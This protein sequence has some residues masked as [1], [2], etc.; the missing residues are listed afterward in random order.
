MKPYLERPEHDQPL[1]AL[2]PLI[3]TP[4][5]FRGTHTWGRPAEFRSAPNRLWLPWHSIHRQDHGNRKLPHA[6]PDQAPQDQ[7]LPIPPPKPLSVLSHFL[8]LHRSVP[9]LNTS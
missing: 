1:V 6:G 8:I 5:P 2:L 3:S 4:D 9:P 7:A